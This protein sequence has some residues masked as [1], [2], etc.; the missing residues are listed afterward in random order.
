MFQ[1][2]A[3]GVFALLLMASV[4]FCVQAATNYTDVDILSFALNLEVHYTNR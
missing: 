3:L 1:K 4:D 2:G